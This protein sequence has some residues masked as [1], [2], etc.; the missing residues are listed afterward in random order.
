MADVSIERGVELEDCP[1]CGEEAE[2]VRETKQ[3]GIGDLIQ[4]TWQAR[5]AHCE[6]GTLK[7]FDRGSAVESWNRRAKGVTKTEESN[8]VKL[9]FDIVQ[10]AGDIKEISDDML[11]SLALDDEVIAGDLTDIAEGIICASRRIIQ[12]II[13]LQTELYKKWMEEKQIAAIERPWPLGTATIGG[14]KHGADT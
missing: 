4:R 13:D 8:I 3:V 2:L 7:Y 6:I 14:A 10:M 12:E 11:H 5:C 9:V 1:F